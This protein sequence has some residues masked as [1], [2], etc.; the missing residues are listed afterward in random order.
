VTTAAR[1]FQG[2]RY[3]FVIS[4]GL[5]EPSRG[6]SYMV[7]LTYPGTAFIP[8]LRHV[9]LPGLIEYARVHTAPF[10]PATSAKPSWPHRQPA[11]AHHPSR[12]VAQGGEI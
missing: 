12:H 5:R 3:L 2:R 1:A 8:D 7:R 10:L 11:F 6:E 9:W 4:E